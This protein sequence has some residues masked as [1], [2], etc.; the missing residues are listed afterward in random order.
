MALP[1]LPT[2]AR[3]LL[4]LAQQDKA[5]ARE[6]FAAL[7]IDG[8]VELL[9]TTPVT[10]RGEL[11]NLA[12]EPEKLVPRLPEAELCFTVKGIGLEA[13]GWVLEHATSEQIVAA[14]DLDAWNGDIPSLPALDD[15][16]A[17]LAEAGDETLLRSVRALDPEMMVLELRRRLMVWL[18]PSGD[19]DWVEPDQSRTLEGQ[20]YW[21]A[22][23]QADDVAALER[24]LRTLIAEDYWL[25]FRLL[26]G[27]IWEL[28]TETEV[29]AER[30][31]AG[32]LEDLGFP[33]RS[34]AVLA[35][36]SHLAPED[37]AGVPAEARA[38]DIEAWRLPVGQPQLPVAPDARHA[39]FRAAAALSSEDRTAFLYALL[40]LANAIAVAD[41]M[42]L[43][44]AESTPRAIERAAERTS[45]GLEHL[46]QATGLSHEDLLRRLPLT[47]LFRIGVNLHGD[48]PPMDPEEAAEEDPE[49]A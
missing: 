5:A 15:W 25:Y 6:A 42:P 30:W 1:S 34:E 35:L 48:L 37:I 38:L 8:Q 22:R 26:Q 4:D 32:R 36:Y 28:D 40:A 24:V 20:F 10:R 14:V 3:R 19:N 13:A 2:P 31:R 17:A 44:D 16:L 18:K 49:L 21:R 9:C 12:R 11:L 46:G 43:G 23:N 41:R 45:D 33:A 47:R 27:A 7:P 29:W 39:V